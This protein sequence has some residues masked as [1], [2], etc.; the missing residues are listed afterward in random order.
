MQGLSLEKTATA[1]AIN[2]ATDIAVWHPALTE[3]K[4]GFG[5]V[6]S[7]AGGLLQKAFYLKLRPGSRAG[8]KRQEFDRLMT[9]KNPSSSRLLGWKL[10][11]MAS[12]L[13]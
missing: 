9:V 2:H 11:A 7:K 12:S 6:D 1:R 8:P 13:S 10:S 4:S 3:K 5:S